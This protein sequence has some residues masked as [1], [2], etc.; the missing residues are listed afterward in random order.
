MKMTVNSFASNKFKGKVL[1]AFQTDLIG[2]ADTKASQ[3]LK[4]RARKGQLSYQV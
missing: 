2:K 3:D 1:F 4:P